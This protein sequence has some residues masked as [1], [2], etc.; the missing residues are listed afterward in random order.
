MEENPE[1]QAANLRVELG[2]LLQAIPERSADLSGII[3][4]VAKAK[5]NLV[6]IQEAS[7]LALEADKKERDAMSL[8]RAELAAQHIALE[9]EKA[10]WTTKLTVSKEEVRLANKELR[11]VNDKIFKGE[12]E[13]KTLEGRKEKLQA[14]INE[15]ILLVARIEELKE[16]VATLQSQ[17]QNVET[18]AL[19]VAEST[20]AKLIS[21]A[22][23]L[24]EME[25]KTRQKV[26]EAAEAE[27]RLKMYTDQ[28]Y[29]HMNDYA[30]VKARLEVQWKQVFP[31]LEL[32]LQ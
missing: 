9:A 12:D 7:T 17:R 5:S 15:M 16:Q 22:K 30:I 23:K 2:Y 19:H 28:L 1:V 14:D 20:E 10:D 21:T 13:V 8:E 32:P 26:V 11:W 18:E 31:E 25:E 6:A 4:Q 3:K 27:S 24:A 29:S